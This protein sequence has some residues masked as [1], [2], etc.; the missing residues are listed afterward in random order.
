ML[1]LMHPADV[2]DVLQSRQGGYAHT[3][4]P[5]LIFDETLRAGHSSLLSDSPQHLLLLLFIFMLS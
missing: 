2:P 1:P 3:H 4:S 5:A